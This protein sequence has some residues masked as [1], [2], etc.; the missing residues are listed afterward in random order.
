MEMFENWAP[1]WKKVWTRAFAL[2]FSS[3]CSKILFAV[4]YC[5]SI[6]FHTEDKFWVYKIAEMIENFTVSSRV[7]ESP[8]ISGSCWNGSK[9]EKTIVVISIVCQ[10]VS[11]IIYYSISLQMAKIYTVGE[12]WDF[13]DFIVV[14]SCL[15][16]EDVHQFE[17]LYKKYCILLQNDSLWV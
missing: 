16:E 15:F 1:C 2:F 3:F 10:N 14:L 8:N 9:S 4:R 5:R 6:T 13:N 7:Q 17:R 11:C 12:G